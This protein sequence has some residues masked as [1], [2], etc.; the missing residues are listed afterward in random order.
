MLQGKGLGAPTRGNCA[1]PNNTSAVQRNP[2]W[3]GRICAAD[4]G[5][6]VKNK[7]TCVGTT[8]GKEPILHLAEVTWGYIYVYKYA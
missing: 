2:P 7:K 6:C 3:G 8:P 5:L 4:S 1:K